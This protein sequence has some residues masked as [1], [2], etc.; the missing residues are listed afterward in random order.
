MAGQLDASKA[1]EAAQPLDGE[2]P[3]GTEQVQQGVTFGLEIK[4]ETDPLLPV[5]LVKTLTSIC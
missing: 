1:A 5:A 4:I 2:P 3:N